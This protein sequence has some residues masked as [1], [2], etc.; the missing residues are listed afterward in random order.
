MSE[1][2][3]ISPNEIFY[4]IRLSY[5]IPSLVEK[6]VTR[7]IITRAAAEAN[8]TVE[9]SELQQAADNWRLVNQ[10]QDVNQ[11]W[12]WLQKHHLS[13]EEFEELI[14]A[15]V[16]SS[17]L[18]QHLFADKVES[19]FVEHQ[20]DYFGAII[21]EIVLD[22]E[23]LAMELFYALTEEEISFFDVAHEY[24]SDLELRRI[25]GYRGKILRKEL[26]PEVSSAI[27]AA[28][29]PQI[30]KPVVTSTGI[31]L[32]KVEELIQPKLDNPLRQKILSDLFNGWIKQQI[33]LLNIEFD[34]SFS[35]YS[36]QPAE[37]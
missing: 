20:L 26:K 35:V 30:L 9:S 22:D 25:G 16:V 21:Y 31:H 7:N 36:N 33:K 28:T 10:L 37:A 5:Q 15:T 11:T 17:K 8:I 18:A 24:I 1:V 32:I 27:F 23:D 29:P 34:Q 4:Q 12:M 2:F 13:L 3:K 6:I 19:F 14:H